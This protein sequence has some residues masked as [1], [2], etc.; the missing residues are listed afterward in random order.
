ME[1]L[2]FDVRIFLFM[3]RVLY[4]ICSGCGRLDVL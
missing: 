4:I 3:L 1:T 2:E